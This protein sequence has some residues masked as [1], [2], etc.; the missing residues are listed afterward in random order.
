MTTEP[1]RPLEKIRPQETTSNEEFLIPENDASPEESAPI[2]QPERPVA[3]EPRIKKEVSFE[4]SSF[5]QKL[6]LQKQKKTPPIPP[7]AQPKDELAKKVEAVLSEGLEEMYAA[8]PPVKKVEFRLRG[9]E[10]ASAIRQVLQKTHINLKKIFKLLMSW[11]KIL[12]GVSIF[13]LEKEAKIK[14]EKIIE[15]EKE[16]NNLP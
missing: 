1:L 13:F 11:L 16:K 2:I 8:L 3:A 10:T 6:K 4:D 5:V 7:P 9:E 14:T 12:P 15:L